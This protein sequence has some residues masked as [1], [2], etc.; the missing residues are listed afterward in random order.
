M[1]AGTYLSKLHSFYYEG[2]FP[3]LTYPI[4][5]R[6]VE[7][8]TSSVILFGPD[9]CFPVRVTAGE[10]AAAVSRYGA[11]H[12]EKVTGEAFPFVVDALDAAYTCGPVRH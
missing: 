4:P 1:S 12:P 2:R 3:N 9:V 6:L 10:L 5:Q 8:Y 7:A 11:A